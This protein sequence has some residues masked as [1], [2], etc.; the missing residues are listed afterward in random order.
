[1]FT[2]RY[3]W[4]DNE[5]IT[6]SRAL[7]EAVIRSQLLQNPKVT[8]RPA[9]LVSGLTMDD[10]AVT[11][12]VVWWRDVHGMYINHGTML[13]MPATT[14]VQLRDGAT[15]T[16]D[17]VVD[18]AGRASQASTWLKELG[19]EAPEE[20]SINANV[21]YNSVNVKPKHDLVW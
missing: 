18:A 10:D 6:A 7:I 9:S 17:L 8:V 19:Y 3:K 2:I 1:M 21:V 14:G 11:G 12:M 5:G 13:T 16:A 4:E 15:M 20:V